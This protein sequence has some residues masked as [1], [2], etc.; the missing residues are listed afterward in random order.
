MD[1]PS[2]S[3]TIDGARVIAITDHLESMVQ[4]RDSRG[5]THLINIS[6]ISPKSLP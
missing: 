2:G 4:S 3:G 1:C 6:I 5:N